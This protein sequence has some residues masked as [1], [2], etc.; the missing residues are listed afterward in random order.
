VT[1]QDVEKLQKSGSFI[2]KISV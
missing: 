2:R 1:D